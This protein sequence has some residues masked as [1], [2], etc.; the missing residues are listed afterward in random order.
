MLE[1][2]PKYAKFLKE[3]L[4]N[5]R[6]LY[7]TI[8]QRKLPPNL[9]DLRSF[10]IPCTIGDFDFDKLLCDLGASVNLMPLFIFKK[11]ELGEVKSTTVCL[12]LADRS[13]KHPRGIIEDV[14]TTKFPSDVDACFAISVLD[15]V[16]AET[17][18]ETFPIS[19][20]ENCIMNEAIHV[21]NHTLKKVPPKLELKLLPSHLKYAF[22]EDSSFYPIIIN[23]SLNDLEEEK[24]LRVLRKHRKAIGW[25]INDIKGISPVIC[26]HKILFEENYRPTV[27]PQQRLNPSMQEVVKKEV[28][29]LLDAGIIYPIS[30]STWVSPFQVVPKKRGIEVDRAK[31][32]VIEKLPPPT[33]VKGDA[34]FDF[35]KEC[36]NAFETLKSKLISSPVIVTPDWKLLCDCLYRPFSFKSLLLQEFDLEIKDKKGTE[37]LVADHLSRM[38]HVEP[39]EEVD[40]DINERFLDEQ[41]FAVEEAPWYANIVNY[42][43]KKILPPEL[44]YQ[45]RNKFFSDLKY[46]IWDDPFLYKQCANQIIRRCVLK[47]RIL[48]HCHSQLFDV[49]GIDF[50]GP[51]PSSY[52]NLLFWLLYITFPNWLKL[53]RCRPMMLRWWLNFLRRTFFARFGTQR[54]IISDGGSH[55]C[56][57]QFES[58]LGKYG[59]THRI[60]TPY[61]PKLDDALWPYRTTFKTP[62]GMSPY[63]LVYGKSRHLPVDLEHK[64]FWAVKLLNFDLRIA[65]EKR[66]LQLNEME[67]FRN[68]AYG[69]AKIY[70]NKAKRW[71]DKHIQ[72][73]DF[74]V[75]QQVHLFNSRLKLFL[76]E[77]GLFTYPMKG[78]ATGGIE[79]PG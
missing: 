22:L 64:S 14:L 32:D 42:L 48:H 36:L 38:N 75:G 54:A 74:E 45:R 27:Q 25:T 66:L 37:N 7:S 10:T 28:V 43:A 35:S 72:K 31:I 19:P 77:K 51:F 52:A 47:R 71:H 24:L 76:G 17:F 63:Q 61:H 56:N 68:N 29:K 33:N 3:V 41:L 55:F 4:S 40:D 46:Y 78:V 6:K 79:C 34:V 57:S 69:N 73:R 70:K 62:I 23:S 30:D 59:V 49:W 67:E 2:M 20:L 12:Q 21:N 60:A 8:L 16:V 39:N 26:M 13:I 15:K 1:K 5:K 65:G 58:L 11:L 53:R 9:K 18:H 44:T 50:M